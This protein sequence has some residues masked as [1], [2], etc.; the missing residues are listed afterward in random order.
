MRPAGRN[1]GC[2]KC[3][4]R[5]Y[6]LKSAE[7]TAT[8][9]ECKMHGFQ[10]NKQLDGDSQGGGRVAARPAD[11][12]ELWVRDRDHVALR[13]LGLVPPG[14]PRSQGSAG[15]RLAKLVR[16]TRPQPWPRVP[17]LNSEERSVLAC[18]SLFFLALLSS[19]LFGVFRFGFRGEARR[20]SDS[21]WG[22]ALESRPKLDIARPAARFR[23][24]TPAKPQ[25]VLGAP[26]PRP[27]APR[28][29]GGPCRTRKGDGP[30]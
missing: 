7:S 5:R 29:T 4:A 6:P 15:G 13:L 19:S 25:E 1:L 30:T 11:N 20:G 3:T 28:R 17:H 22:A 16:G 21:V 23:R 27:A 18:S 26:A 12:R 10:H 9:G 14:G 8:R 2:R 24:P